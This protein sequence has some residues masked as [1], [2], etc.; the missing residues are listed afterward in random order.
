MENDTKQNE[1]DGI[2]FLFEHIYETKNFWW[3][4]TEQLEQTNFGKQMENKPSVI[5]FCW[6]PSLVHLNSSSIFDLWNKN[7][8]K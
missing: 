7:E 1:T 2:L 4:N 8:I 5:H 6:K 3:N